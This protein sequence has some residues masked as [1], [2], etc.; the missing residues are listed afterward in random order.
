VRQCPDANRRTCHRRNS[1]RRAV[2]VLCSRV[3][4]GIELAAGL[5]QLPLAK[6]SRFT[7]NRLVSWRIQGEPRTCS[8]CQHANSTDTH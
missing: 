1:V 4:C 3:G 2:P 8:R 7:Y 6:R 5:V